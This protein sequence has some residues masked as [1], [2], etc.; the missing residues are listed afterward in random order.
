MDDLKERM[1]KWWE[2]DPGHLFSQALTR[3]ETLEKELET[4][5]GFKHDYKAAFLSVLYENAVLEAR[6]AKADA[7]VEAHLAIVETTEGLTGTIIQECRQISRKALSE[8]AKPKVGPD[9]D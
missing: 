6:I 4:E 9:F 1:R 3:I 7:L 5:T 8:I 2:Y